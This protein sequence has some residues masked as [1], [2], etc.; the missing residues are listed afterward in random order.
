MLSLERNLMRMLFLGTQT[1]HSTP[2]S[3]KHYHD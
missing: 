2:H 3:K 1:F